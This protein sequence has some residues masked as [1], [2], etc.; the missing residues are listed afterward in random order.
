MKLRPPRIVFFGR[1]VLGVGSLC[2]QCLFLS[3]VNLFTACADQTRQGP[4]PYF[5]EVTPPAKRELRWSNG[6][7]PRSFDPV[8]AAAP[9]ETDIIRAIY[10]GLTLADPKTFDAVPGVAEKWMSPDNGRTWTFQ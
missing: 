9:P 10:E 6:K 2:A 7:L 1:G 4:S 8:Q 5:A 3:L